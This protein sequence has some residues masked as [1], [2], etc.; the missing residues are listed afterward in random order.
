MVNW[1]IVRLKFK[2]IIPKSTR[3]IRKESVLPRIEVNFELSA[4]SFLQLAISH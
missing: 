4:F 1:F 2:N 3:K